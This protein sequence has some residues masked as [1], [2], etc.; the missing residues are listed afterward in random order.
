MTGTIICSK[1]QGT[2]G[3]VKIRR[4]Q[5]ED[6]REIHQLAT[7]AFA[8]L[9]Y[10]DG[11]EPTIIDNLRAA[12]DLALSL[13]ALK[14]NALVGHVAFSP[15]RIGIDTSTWHGLGPVSVR[16]EFQRKGIGSALIT[17]G[18][19]I[20]EHMGADGCA[21]IGDPDYYCRFGFISDGR[22]QYQDL[23][24]EVVQ[25]KSFGKQ[26]PEGLLLYSPAFGSE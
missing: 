6:Q 4:E 25:W 24:N 23:P 8:G 13:V 10:S 3:Y 18:L 21:L 17:K 11:S 22:I 2:T 14:G 1:N 9:S 12:G 5:P 26:R 15:V 19:R 7:D 16:P 20:L